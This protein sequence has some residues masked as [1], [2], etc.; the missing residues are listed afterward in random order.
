MLLVCYPSEVSPSTCA[1]KLIH[2]QPAPGCG[3][4]L[5]SLWHYQLFFLHRFIPMSIQTCLKSSC[6]FKVRVLPFP[7]CSS[8]CIITP[9]KS[10]LY[11]PLTVSYLI[12]SL[13]HSIQAFIPISLLELLFSRSPMISILPNPSQFSDL[14]LIPSMTCSLLLKALNFHLF[15]G[16]LHILLLFLFSLGH[17]L[18]S[19]FL[20]HP[21]PPISKCWGTQGLYPQFFSI[22]AH[23]LNVLHLVPCSSCYL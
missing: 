14:N 16:Q 9:Q 19:A 5:S 3:S 8:L 7:F 12:L 21:L 23:S 1:L 13:T 22:F 18:R 4:P 11:L 17:T 2:S 10:C 20:I 6:F 15:S